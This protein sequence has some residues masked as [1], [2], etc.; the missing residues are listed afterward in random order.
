MTRDNTRRQ[1]MLISFVIPCFRSTDTVGYVVES[2]EKLA[3]A[4]SYDTEI[5]L[6]NDGPKAATFGKLRELHER[7]PNI[8]AVDLSK[9][10]GQQNALMA[11]FQ[12]IA[13]DLVVVC[14]DDGQTPVDALPQMLELLEKDD[15]DVVFAHYVGTHNGLFRRFGSAMN[16]L[17]Q[18][19]F[20]D[21]SDDVVTSAFWLAKRFIVEEIKRYRNPYPYMSGLLLR[22]TSRIGNVELTQ[23]DRIA[24][25]SGYNFRKLLA[26]WIS[27]VTTCSA[28]PLRY[29]S[30]AGVMCAFIGFITLLV[31]VIRKLIGMDIDEGW[32]SLIATILLV[33][34]LILMV[35][36][37]IGEYVGR[38][39]ISINNTP[40]Y[41][42]REVLEKKER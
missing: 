8:I 35:L 26:L 12:H 4:N 1:Q 20:L 27:G 5:I 38:I 40:Q 36:G 3:E 34:G 31:L 15:L 23:N 9:N 30:M 18:K 21:K 33:G 28:K 16:N 24:G 7:Y 14:D 29:S 17:M 37:M 10:R 32:T 25:S 11:G 13:G 39:Y 2:I 42:E 6:V 22:T 19:T 41:V